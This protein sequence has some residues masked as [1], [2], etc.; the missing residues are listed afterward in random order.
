MH[1]DEEVRRWVRDVVVAQHETWLAEQGGE[2]VA[3]MVLDGEV[4]DQL[5]VHPTWTGH[6]AG[7]ELVRLAQS[8]RPERL[9]LWTFQSNLGARRFYERHGFIAVERTDGR[10]NEEREPDVRYLWHGRP[11]SSV[12]RC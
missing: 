2:L 8:R 6:G 5:Y 10:D 7:S 9:W 1:P 11:S 12:A 3:M 4:L